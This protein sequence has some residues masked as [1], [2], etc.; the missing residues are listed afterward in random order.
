MTNR[1]EQGSKRVGWGRLAAAGLV[2]ALLAW[3]GEVRA[4]VAYVSG[5]SNTP[6]VN[7]NPG[8]VTWNSGNLSV[9]PGAGTNR[10]LVVVV[11][12]RLG[13]SGN[14][15]ASATY[16]G[17]TATQGVVT[18][19]TNTTRG[20][21]I[22]Y[23]KES[24]LPAG[25]AN[26]SVTINSAQS[27]IGVTVYA[28]TFSGVDQTTPLSGSG[29]T[30][31][32]SAT[33]ITL[34]TAVPS[35]AN[36]AYVAAVARSTSATDTLAPAT[37]TV[38]T[39]DN[40]SNVGGTI[41]YKLTPSGGSETTSSTLST[42]GAQA[43][44]VIALNPL[45]NVITA[46]NGS[47]DPTAGTALGAGTAN[48]VL[49]T[50]TLQAT[51]AMTVSAVGVT[52]TG[53]T[54]FSSVYL[55]TSATCSTPL[56]TVTSPGTSVSFTGLSLSV[57]T[58][59][60]ANYYVCGT[61][62]S[63]VT[64]ATSVSAN[65]SSVTPSSGTWSLTDNDTGP[66]LSAQP[67][68]TLGNGSADPTAGTVIYE[69][70]TNNVLDTFTLQ[71]TTSG[72][73]SAV[74]VTMTGPTAF[75]S[76][77]LSTSATCSSPLSTVTSPG[78]SVSFT[79]LSLSVTTTA[80]ANYYICGTVSSS[81][82]ATTS[83][84]AN[85]SSVTM[86]SGT[87]VTTDNDGGPTLS[88]QPVTISIGQVTDPTNSATAGQ[89]A[90]IDAFSLQTNYGNPTVSSLT[91]TLT[92]SS[93]LT[94]V[95][96]YST[97]T[98]T[99]GTQYGTSQT[100][101]A[102]VTF[103]S[104]T[105][106]ATTTA[107]TYY[108][109]GTAG[110]VASSTSVTAVVASGTTSSSSYTVNA[111]T[112]AAGTLTVT[113]K[114]VLIGQVT[115]PTNS[116]TAGQT[117]AVDAFSLS[118]NTGNP[119]V[120][121]L[122][123][124]LTNSS[125]LTSV[126][127][128]SASGCTGGTQYGTAQTPAASVSFTGLT[129]SLSTTA[130]TYYV[131][132]T[133]GTVA[134]STSVTAVVASGTTSSS[135]Y[136]VNASTDAAG[137]LTVTP[138]PVPG[139]TT[140]SITATVNSCTQV[141]GSASYTGDTDGDNT[142]TFTRSTDG[143][144]FSAI[145]CTGTVAGANPR[146]CVD[147]NALANT[148]YWYRAQFTDSTGGVSGTN[149]IT[150]A[151]SV[152]TGSCSTSLALSDP[153]AAG[154][155]AAAN[156]TAGTLKAPVG[157]I[158]LTATGGATG[159]AGLNVQNL[160][161]AVAGAD[162]TGLQLWDSTCTTTAYAT[163]T[164]Y[165][166]NLK[167]WIF[168]GTPLL[169][170]PTTATTYCLTMNTSSSAKVG[171]TFDMQVASADLTASSPSTVTGTVTVNSAGTMTIT[172]PSPVVAQEGNANGGAPMVLLLN[173]GDG[174]TVSQSGG[175]RVQVQ[176]FH[177]PTAAGG[178]D[179]LSK[180][181][182]LTLSVD[183]AAGTSMLTGAKTN[184]DTLVGPNARI[185]ELPLSSLAAGTHTLQATAG[186]GTYTTKSRQVVVNVVATTVAGD[187][188]LLV[189]DNASQACTDCHAV[190]THSSQATMPTTT[191]VQK[192]GAW[193]MNCRDCHT[194]HRTPNIYVIKPNIN[195]PNL[196]TTYLSQ[197]AI[198]FSTTVGDSQTSTASKASFVNSDGS[199][200][201]QA[202]HTRTAN[203]TNTSLYRWRNSA[204]G[205]NTDSH[206][207][208][209]NTQTCTNCHAHTG[210]FAGGESGGGVNCS[211]CHAT[212]W[213]SMNG[214][215]A[216]STAH[217]IGSVI[218]TNDSYVDTSTQAW[219][220]TNF[221]TAVP[222]A[223]RSCVGMCHGDHVHDLTSGTTT[224]T[225]HLY[226]AYVDASTYAARA[227]NSGAATQTKATTTRAMKDYDSTATNGGMCISCH[228]NDADANHPAIDKTK[229][230]ASAHDGYTT[231]DGTT[232]YTW[233]YNIHDNS[234]FLRDCTKCHASPTEGTTPSSG[235][236]IQGPHYS[237]NGS[238][239]AGKTQGGA[240]SGS[241]TL[242]CY[243]CH[244]NGTTGKN[245]SSKDLATPFSDASAHPVGTD[246]IHNTVTEATDS[247]QSGKFSGANRH[248]NCIDCHMPHM[249]GNTKHSP[250]TN[251]IP[252]ASP[253]KWETG[254]SF[255]SSASNFF[256]LAGTANFWLSTSVPSTSYT[257]I[258]STTGVTAEAQVCFKCH[259]NWTASA[260][261]TGRSGMTETNVALDFSTGNN[262]Y[263]P[264]LGKLFQTLNA[265]QLCTSATAPCGSAWTP[266]S[267]MTCSDCHGSDANTAGA[268][269]PHGSAGTF[270]L[271][272]PQTAWP[273]A[274]GSTSLFNSPYNAQPTGVNG[275]FCLNC[276]PQPTTTNNVHRD[277][278][279]N[280]IACVGCHVAVPHGGKVQRLLGGQGAPTPY[281][282]YKYGSGPTAPTSGSTGICY[283]R[284][285]A[286]AYTG[287]S[288]SNCNTSCAHTCST[289]LQS[290]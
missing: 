33:T 127:L 153:L 154:Q 61:V 152:N 171:N 136:T 116:A 118:A 18:S 5:F 113:P 50:F 195:P 71:G 38:P 145:T 258:P 134:S 42:S 66:T 105:I 226:N 126:F 44:G 108:V 225:N 161:T 290:W 25:A 228:L 253:L 52:M 261:P 89:T 139:T 122:T 205:G 2:F 119:T 248:V 259:S 40:T 213:Q 147:S 211:G 170:V 4:Q 158:I 194:P 91:V 199:G 263:H 92:N 45:S 200:P 106:S 233:Q 168:S 162:V 197:V 11:P 57:T 270:I 99:G 265:A 186:D 46:G 288:S 223:S 237:A 257:W 14:F 266:G 69:A 117:A 286:P 53:P 264:V 12:M 196:G 104:L 125:A 60:S 75:S 120:S 157:K 282:Y 190:K 214:T 177:P 100:P 276:H 189:R 173:P 17:Y 241:G 230:S 206:Y 234:A 102:S 156:V 21:W 111:S 281:K 109:C 252:T 78:T 95:F 222:Q 67:M 27:F 165:S 149:P 35:N 56:A 274:P 284:G 74:G 110:T 175:F 244:G 26:L 10:V 188:N 24:Q 285:S 271:K 204:A 72:T 272:G 55:S 47:A 29:E 144:T 58:T 68:V 130:T 221:K 280:G 39:T 107:T 167:R 98:C 70:T 255:V 251:V 31:S 133:A 93:A 182:T 229:Y 178:T 84:S 216:S 3:A 180:I 77:Y 143:T 185:Y 235:G 232:T 7:A 140:G 65:V 239:L 9:T 28:G 97:A 101:A 86:S 224:T 207:S 63:S 242:V 278:N 227:D 159:L 289:N 137:T 215:I 22:G 172:A 19:N 243:N 59:A 245:F 176:A 114:L 6:L 287:W 148:S 198:K 283:A 163:T 203:P 20:V 231:S 174:Q 164:S 169:S 115:D 112:D 121:A 238:L 51:S 103:S 16:N 36:G 83:V 184:F 236:A 32:S 219:N 128:Y 187:G 247:F 80:S 275:L 277:N 48:N 87:W 179:G 273:Y 85:V 218:G 8:T 256:G 34:G 254:V 13:S 49:D 23:F 90:A 138:P 131:C 54:A 209:G 96:L 30:S 212:T 135:G 82:A 151:S 124:T 192:Y 183:G 1:R 64:T 217:F 202:C 15:S 123:V 249:A 150:T 193:G 260:A 210:G 267:V 62:S 208:A 88:A 155:P 262:S 246:T 132:G 220:V 76:V 201:C 79:G 41:G 181:T 279:H 250:G 191:N 240:T 166:S 94:S 160:G 81:L 269:G 146:L 129:I 141:T 142:V 268:Q 73:V 43:L 37:Y